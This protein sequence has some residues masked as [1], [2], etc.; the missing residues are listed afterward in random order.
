MDPLHDSASHLDISGVSKIFYRLGGRR[1]AGRWGD[2]GA[3]RTQFRALLAFFSLLE[4]TAM[5][6]LRRKQD[7]VGTSLVHGTGKPL[8]CVG[9]TVLN[10]AVVSKQD[11]LRRPPAPRS[12]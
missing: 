5:H 6:S 3:V 4:L 7:A 10:D 12:M 9:K 2:A 1:G 8:H 11:G